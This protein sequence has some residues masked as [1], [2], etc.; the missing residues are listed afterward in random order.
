MNNI[1][2]YGIAFLA[3][4]LVVL[5]FDGTHADAYYTTNQSAV[6][7]EESVGLY[8]IDFMFAHEDYDI[9]IPIIATRAP[10]RVSDTLLSYTVLDRNDTIVEDG[11]SAGIVLS[12]AKIQNG[13]YIVPK[14]TV[15]RFTLLTLFTPTNTDTPNEFRTHVTHL[16][17]SFDGTRQLQLNQSELVK[18][19]TPLTTLR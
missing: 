14:G 4:L 15:R 18:Y 1:T 13:M 2:K 16:P 11:A 8:T 19:T 5:F 9:Y 6:T 17:F 7:L 3:L 12:N 10:E